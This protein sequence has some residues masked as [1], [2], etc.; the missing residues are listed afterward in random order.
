[1]KLKSILYSGF[2]CLVG[3][4]AAILFA[5][6]V[7][8]FTLS[9]VAKTGLALVM[10]GL[11]APKRESAKP[12]SPIAA[13]G[14][15]GFIAYS[16][17]SLMSVGLAWR[18]DSILFYTFPALSALASSLN[19]EEGAART[20][21]FAFA[22]SFAAIGAWVLL[23]I[24]FPGVL[25]ALK[26]LVP[27]AAA[28]FAARE[29][30]ESEVS[31]SRTLPRA[32]TLGFLP[33]VAVLAVAAPAVVA[34]A[35][36]IPVLQVVGEHW[37]SDADIKK[38]AAYGLS[39]L[40][41]PFG[42]PEMKDNDYSGLVPQILIKG[43]T[44]YNIRPRLVLRW[45]Y[46]QGR[47]YPFTAELRYDE[48][49]G[50]YRD[51]TKTEKSIVMKGFAQ[52]VPSSEGPAVA[53][54]MDG[55]AD[56]QIALDKLRTTKFADA[57]ATSGGSIG[58]AAAGAAPIAG[59]S[60]TATTQAEKGAEA[61]SP[62]LVWVVTS[63]GTQPLPRSKLPS[64][65]RGREVEV[66]YLNRDDFKSR[67]E[68]LGAG[69]SP[70]DLIASQDFGA[71]SYLSQGY[72]QD[73]RTFS[74]QNLQE[75]GGSSVFVLLPST[76]T[77]FSLLRE[78]AME[79][80]TIEPYFVQTD[81]SL[82][83]IAEASEAYIAGDMGRLQPFLHPS[84]L[85]TAGSFT[86]KAETH[87]AKVDYTE[88]SSSIIAA[89]ARV[90]FSTENMLGVSTVASIWAKEGGAWKALVVTDD[91]LVTSRIEAIGS[92]FAALDGGSSSVV[93]A[94][95]SLVTPDGEYPRP[96]PGQN[97]GDFV[98]IPSPGAA[99]G[100][101]VEFNYGTATRLFYLP[102]A[103]SGRLSTGEL[104]TTNSRWQWRVWSF[105]NSGTLAFSSTRSFD[106]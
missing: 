71:R 74:T 49:Y 1:M 23:P 62:L 99:G 63:P 103:E 77:N 92:N 39:R 7:P 42:K 98:W 37:V 104:W 45:T 56:V 38:A 8:S 81:A 16:A 35:D 22:G 47:G 64:S 61:Q 69:G 29:A 66:I 59:V 12:T 25:S 19:R 34:N 11:M 10:L 51:W 44:Y 82:A 73:Q 100:E 28:Y 33:A 93:P 9:L 76:A 91:P 90:P 41:S 4:A 54:A 36:S 94:P 6:Q 105:S 46:Q 79:L 70:P 75:F 60:Q 80:R 2:G 5:L 27:A 55:Y 57:G 13:A 88:G 26:Y 101:V 65:F 78:A 87:S 102:L 85:Q 30:G 15:A 17:L 68:G 40:L 84:S 67:I 89:L 3:V 50:I 72:G 53:L 52:R 43:H 86:G 96:S 31:L 97:Y 14:F 21:G 95:A 24:P 106:H 83:S 20:W 32:A 18:M 48:Y 58:N